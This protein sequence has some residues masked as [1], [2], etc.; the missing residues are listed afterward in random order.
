MI[1]DSS[2]LKRK[3]FLVLYI[4]FLPAVTILEIV[5]DHRNQFVYDVNKHCFRISL[6]LVPLNGLVQTLEFWEFRRNA[7]ARLFLALV[8]CFFTFLIKHIGIASVYFY[9]IVYKTVFE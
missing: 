6:A 8:F 9:K 1:F 3:K 5:G 2:S 4:H 7:Y